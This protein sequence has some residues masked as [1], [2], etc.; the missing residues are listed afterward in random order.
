MLV[1]TSL[2]DGPKHRHSIMEDVLCLSGISLGPGTLHWALA[3]L[4]Q[5]GWIQQL[6]EERRRQSYEITDAGRE[7]LTAECIGLRSFAET[8]LARG[9][10]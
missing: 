6:P 7:F 10:T 3:R 5:R 4:E 1:L 8:V 2:A 9:N